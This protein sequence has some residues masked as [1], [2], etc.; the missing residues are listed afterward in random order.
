[1]SNICRNE[2]VIR[3][4]EVIEYQHPGN[5]GTIYITE[6]GKHK[7]L[8]YEYSEVNVTTGLPIEITSSEA[9]DAVLVTENVGK[10]YIYAGPTNEKYV[11]G[12]KYEIMEE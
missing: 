9:M 12:A 10:V 7:V 6:N 1:M 8:N 4:K 11:N 3:L 5:K 2:I